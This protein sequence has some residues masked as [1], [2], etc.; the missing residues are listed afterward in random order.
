MTGKELI[1]HILNNKLVDEEINVVGVGSDDDI[2][3]VSILEVK[4]DDDY[5][6]G[7]LTVNAEIIV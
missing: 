2:E 3:P 5:E 7:I 1:N 6:Q 4:F